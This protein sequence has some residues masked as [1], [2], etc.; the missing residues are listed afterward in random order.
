MEI[1]AMESQILNDIIKKKRSEYSNDDW[2]VMVLPYSFNINKYDRLLR[3]LYVT[4]D[5]VGVRASDVSKR[6][7]LVDTFTGND[8]RVYAIYNLKL[9]DN[10]NQ[11]REIIS[12][13]GGTD[14]LSA[15]F[16][17]RMFQNACAKTINGNCI[18]GDRCMVY[19]S[20][21]D[22][23]SKCAS[24]LD[25]IV[26]EKIV[27]NI[28]SIWCGQNPSTSDC[29]CL[30]RHLRPNYNTL[31]DKVT[32]TSANSY[33]RDEC[34]YKPCADGG[35]LINSNMARTTCAAEFCINDVNIRGNADVDVRNLANKLECFNSKKHSKRRDTKDNYRIGGIQIILLLFMILTLTTIF[36]S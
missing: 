35:S 23:G 9:I 16:K 25:V 5:I 28:N 7:P 14:Q 13:H 20:G 22:E 6:Q 31:R 8:G 33:M 18:N 34:W 30:A 2:E 36:K 21:T 3:N 11:I 4:T 17:E 15:Y 10:V 1:A 19:R 29:D 32:T 26:D 12:Y 24:L 27:D